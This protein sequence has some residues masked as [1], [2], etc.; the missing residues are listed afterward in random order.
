MGSTT[1]HSPSN[2]HP[3]LLLALA[4]ASPRGGED[5]VDDWV[6]H[7][8]GLLDKHILWGQKERGLG[9]Y[10]SQGPQGPAHFGKG[11]HQVILTTRLA[12]LPRSGHRVLTELVE[13][14]LDAILAWHG[15]DQPC[16]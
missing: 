16:L 2:C 7:I 4:P 12:A 6:P 15:A 14:G 1:S 3:L 8:L 11:A 13:V 9:A 10:P 5:S